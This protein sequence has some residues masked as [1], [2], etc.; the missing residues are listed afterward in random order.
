MYF[1]TAISK[2]RWGI[3]RRFVP[4]VA[5][6]ALRAPDPITA[7]RPVSALREMPAHRGTGELSAAT[8]AA[9]ARTYDASGYGT[10]WVVDFAEELRARSV[11]RREQIAAGGRS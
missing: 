3:R 11:S 10:H 6:G 2:L 8:P 9:C 5:T 4:A 7:S 1:Y